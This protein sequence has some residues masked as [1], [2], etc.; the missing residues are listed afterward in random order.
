MAIDLVADAD[1]TGQMNDTER[2]RRYR[3]QWGYVVG[4]LG[5]LGFA[6]VVIALIGITGAGTEGEPGL[7]LALSI[8]L[9]L[10]VAVGAV[11]AV[12]AWRLE[13]SVDDSE[14]TVRSLRSRTVD[15]STVSR[16]GW[17]GVWFDGPALVF[18]EATDRPGRHRLCTLPMGVTM[19]AVPMLGGGV[20]SAWRSDDSASL[21]AAILEALP[22]DVTFSAEAMQPFAA[23]GHP[24]HQTS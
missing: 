18:A 24:F 14:L 1:G 8:V 17:R 6:A 15:L 22:D 11:V 7:L 16:V 9:A 3:A 5:L 12:A 2:P 19:S 10:F 4:R 13:V 20:V 21:L 23:A